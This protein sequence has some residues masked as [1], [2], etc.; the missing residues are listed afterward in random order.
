MQTHSSISKASTPAPDA[1]WRQAWVLVLAGGIVM[2]LALG[3]RHVQGLFLLPVTMD[4]GWSRETFGFALAIQ[5]LSWGIAQPFTGMVADRFGS[6]K[7]IAAGL[8]FY[9]LGLFL[10]IHADTP[11]GFVWAAG[12]C[13]GIGLSGTTFGAVY[14]AISRLVSPERRSAAL[15][16]S[17]AIGGLVQFAMVPAAQQLLSA[18]SWPGALLALAAAMLLVM[19]LALPLR[20]D[21]TAR[22]AT[23]AEQPLSAALKEAF[24]HSGF[25]MLNLGFLAC[26]FQLAFIATH[27]PAYLLDKGMAPSHAVTALALIALANVLG[28]YSFGLL[29]ARHRRKHL[30]AGIY[31]LRAAAMALFVLL[32]LSPVSLYLFAAVMGFL[33]LGTAPL[34]NGL[35][36]QVFGLRYITTLFGFVFFGHQIGSFLGVWMGSYLFEQTHSYDLIW[37]GAIALGLVAAALQWPINDREI[38]RPALR[39]MPA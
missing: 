17:G 16:L 9:A 3:V 5:N 19:P 36:S 18:W 8:L 21:S 39:R 6:A 1:W 13:I 38:A 29:G 25:W 10:M 28:T 7:V 37:Y 4:R 32:P 11:A 33:W 34:T 14:G 23:E 24:G 22:M 31:L 27:L 26:G 2:G 20:S 30:L 12:L 15:G 35:V